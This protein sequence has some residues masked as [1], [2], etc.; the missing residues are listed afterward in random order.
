MLSFIFYLALLFFLTKGERES[1][2]REKHVLTNTRSMDN[3]MGSIE[4]RVLN[5]RLILLSD[6]LF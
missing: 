1:E 2:G 6:L 3:T 4:D 5:G